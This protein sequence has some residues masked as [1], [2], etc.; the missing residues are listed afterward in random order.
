MCDVHSKIILSVCGTFLVDVY[1]FGDTFLS[2]VILQIVKTLKLIK[3]NV[4][5]YFFTVFDISRTEYKL[6]IIICMC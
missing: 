3:I 2:L 5:L 4:F 6:Q 1:I